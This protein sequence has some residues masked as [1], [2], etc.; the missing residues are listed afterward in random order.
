MVSGALGKP[1]TH[2]LYAVKVASRDVNVAVIIPLRH[3]VA[4]TVSG[5]LW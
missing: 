1:G 5:S 4:L 3:M 2:A